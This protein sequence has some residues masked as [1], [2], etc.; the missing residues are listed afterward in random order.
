MDPLR[1]DAGELTTEEIL[2][3]LREGRRVVVTAE[4]FGD[5]RDLTLRHDGDVFYCDTPTRLHKH[6]EEDEMRSC[7]EEM[8]YGRAPEAEAE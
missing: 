4:L 2:D 6:A 3:T 7:I 1:V 8:G 5:E